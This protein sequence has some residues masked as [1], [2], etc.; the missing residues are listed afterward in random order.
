[1]LLAYSMFSRRTPTEVHGIMKSQLKAD[2]VIFEYHWCA[3]SP[4]R[5][6]CSIL[7][8]Y[9]RIDPPEYLQRT[10]FCELVQRQENIAP[11]TIVF[12]NNMYTV[13]KV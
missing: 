6:E 12:K 9:D 10:P 7:G 11:F 3:R 5:E 8:S 13:L 4:D 1:M 2:Y